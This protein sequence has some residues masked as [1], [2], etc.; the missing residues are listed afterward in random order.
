[1]TGAMITLALVD[2]GCRQPPGDCTIAE[3]RKLTLRARPGLAPENTIA[4]STASSNTKYFTYRGDIWDYQGTELNGKYNRE[5]NRS[6]PQ[7]DTPKAQYPRESRQ[8][9]LGSNEEYQEGR[10]ICNIECEKF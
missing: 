1:M 9:S 8:V 5:V 7:N 4:M 2:T 6:I 10:G 3:E